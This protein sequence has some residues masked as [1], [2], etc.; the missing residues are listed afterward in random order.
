MDE[1]FPGTVL[2]FLSKIMCLITRVKSQT[3]Q[4]MLKQLEKKNK[5]I[6]I[7]CIKYYPCPILTQVSNCSVLCNF[8]FLFLILCDLSLKLKQSS[9]L[10][11]SWLQE[12]AVM[13]WFHTVLGHSQGGNLWLQTLGQNPCIIFKPIFCLL[14]TSPGTKYL[15]P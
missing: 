10:L 12:L 4:Q 6:L 1:I 7:P 9:T 14:L 13:Q 3:N 2:F 15:F 11:L 8:P 5:I